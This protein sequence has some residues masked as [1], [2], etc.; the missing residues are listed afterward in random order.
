MTRLKK[1]VGTIQK[2]QESMGTKRFVETINN[3]NP[4]EDL[5]IRLAGTRAV[6]PLTPKGPGS[7][8]AAGAGVRTFKKL[9]EDMPMGKTREVLER[10]A[11]DPDFMASLL[12]RGK[13]YDQRSFFNIGKRVMRSMQ[14]NGITPFS[15]ATMN[16]FDQKDPPM[17]DEEVERQL[18]GPTTG[19]PAS[20]LLRQLPPA[21]PTTGV[22]GLSSAPRVTPQGPGPRAG[23]AAPPAPPM[24]G[25]P[26]Q[27]NSRQ[28][29]QSL[30]PFDTTL[31]IGSP[32][33]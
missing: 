3:I 13:A 20:Q 14:R 22:P 5:A 28:M 12:E 10:A 4:L 18:F 2:T 19:A 17:T 6:E 31:R 26:Q 27:P 32:V 33:Q 24:P 7:I 23:P 30:F 11:K 16:Y 9:F 8:V 25:Q 1:I 21:P 15:V 29:L